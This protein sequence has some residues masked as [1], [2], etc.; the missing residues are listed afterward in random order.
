MAHRGRVLKS[1]FLTAKV[2]SQYL[3]P[4]SFNLYVLLGY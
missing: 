1:K 4:M 3:T 2:I